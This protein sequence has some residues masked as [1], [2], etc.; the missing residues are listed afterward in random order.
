MIFLN[1]K[2]YRKT[3]KNVENAK[4]R[5]KTNFGSLFH[6]I[7]NVAP[8]ALPTF[9]LHIEILGFSGFH[10]YFWGFFGFRT[11]NVGLKNTGRCYVLDSLLLLF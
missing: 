8:P 3:Q 6:K 5:R 11:K 10:F 2:T 1:M 9:G 4:K 7:S